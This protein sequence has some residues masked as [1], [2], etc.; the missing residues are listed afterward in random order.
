MKNFT[1]KHIIEIDEFTKSKT[2]K[3][4]IVGGYIKPYNVDM[5]K[6][7]GG[8]IANSNTGED[9]IF[10]FENIKERDYICFYFFSKDYKLKLKDKITFLFENDKILSFEVIES[11]VKAKTNWNDLYKTKTLITQDELI[12]FSKQKLWKWKIEFNNKQIPIIGV[13]N[14]FYWY[15]KE[16]FQFVLSNLVDEYMVLVEKNIK[17]HIPLLDRSEISMKETYKYRKCYVYLMCDTTNNFHKIG[18]SN[19]PEYRERTLQAEKPSIELLCAKE[20]PSRVIAES[21]EKSLH[22]SFSEKRIRGEW[23]ELN[24]SEIND[25]IETLK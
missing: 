7:I 18:I 14:N 6:P 8:I 16:N 1:N 20:F 23:F 4:K 19:K 5:P 17:N 25:I 22:M 24:Q 10:S 3:W 11:S 21:I 15:N 2:L 9:L 13:A 12:L